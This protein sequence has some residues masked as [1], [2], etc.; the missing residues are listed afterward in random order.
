MINMRKICIVI[1]SLF[2]VFASQAQ[3]QLS[4]DDVIVLARNKS[5]RSKQI[6]NRYQRSYWRHFSFE[7]QY[8][9]SIFFDG[10]LPKFQRSLTSVTQNDGSEAFVNRNILSSKTLFRSSLI[11]RRVSASAPEEISL[12]GSLYSI[13]NSSSFVQ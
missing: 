9:P 12:L 2:Y 7:R 11:L 13:K 3:N 10:T 6:E 5:I 8:L 1:T 4:L